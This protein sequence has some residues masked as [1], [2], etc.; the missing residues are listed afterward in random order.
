MSQLN[1]DQIFNWLKEISQIEPSPEA[2]GRTKR[3]IFDILIKERNEYVK[4]GA[5][6]R[7]AL[8]MVTIVKFA[9]AALIFIGFGFFAGRLSVPKP[10]DIKELQTVLESSLKESLESSIEENLS[11]Q[12]NM[13][14]ESVVATNFSTLKEE[15]RQQVHNDLIEFTAQTAIA[16][17]KLTERRFNELIDLIEAAR[18]RDREQI[19]AALMQIQRRTTKFGT[20]LIALAAQTDEAL[21]TKQN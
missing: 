13:R 18:Q 20:G 10:V 17:R 12:M 2:A 16:S 5:N 9:V 4:T 11:E 19:E 15:L 14:M 8:F 3:K 7:K 1:K 21:R 6:T